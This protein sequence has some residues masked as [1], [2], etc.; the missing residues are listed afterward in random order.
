[1]SYCE[2]CGSSRHHSEACP[3]R[4]LTR[5]LT[6]QKHDPEK[7]PDYVS[8]IPLGDLLEKTEKELHDEVK[9]LGKI[10]TLKKEVR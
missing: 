7:L 9:N 3:T 6:G 10:S 5:A 1:M 8:M 4:E 2:W